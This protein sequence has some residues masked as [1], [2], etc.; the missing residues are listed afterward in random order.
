MKKDNIFKVDENMK[1]FWNLSTV[2]IKKVLG[3]YGGDG[4]FWRARGLGEHFGM[5]AMKR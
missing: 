2:R 3:S 4:R 1:Q 5:K